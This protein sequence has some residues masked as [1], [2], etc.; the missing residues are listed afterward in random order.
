MGDWQNIA[1]AP[2]DGSDIEI[3]TA[4]GFEMQARFEQLGF[5]N[6]DGKSVGAWVALVED[7]HPDCWTDGACWKSNADEV[8]SDP[9]IMWRPAKENDHG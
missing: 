6:E 2:K 9:P 5:E 4:G 7:H 3:L 8:Q 1:S